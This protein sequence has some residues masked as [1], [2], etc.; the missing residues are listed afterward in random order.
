M[1]QKNVTASYP[2]DTALLWIYSNVVHVPH[3]HIVFLSNITKNPFLPS[4]LLTGSSPFICIFNFSFLIIELIIVFA[5]ITANDYLFCWDLGS[6]G[7]MAGTCV[8]HTLLLATI[9]AGCA[10]QAAS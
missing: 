2:S 1:D 4:S 3:I 6:W 7:Q 8:A 5:A 9:F 10:I